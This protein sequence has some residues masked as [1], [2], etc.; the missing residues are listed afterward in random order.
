MACKQ[1]VLCVC[2]GA[3]VLGI[4]AD[5]VPGKR[6]A[7]REYNINLIENRKKSK[8]YNIGINNDILLN[9]YKKGNS[10]DMIEKIAICSEK[11]SGRRTRWTQS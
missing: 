1:V 9:H 3:L 6:I 2:V 7:K 11:A 5:K 8:I 10:I 4:I